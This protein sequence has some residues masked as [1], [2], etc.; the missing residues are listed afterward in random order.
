MD[1]LLV[2][3]RGGG[4][5]VGADADYERVRGQVVGQRAVVEEAGVEVEVVNFVSVQK[6][7][8]LLADALLVGVHAVGDVN[9]G[10]A[11]IEFIAVG[12]GGQGLVGGYYLNGADY[13]GGALTGGVEEADAVNLVSP[14][15]YASGQ[16]RAHGEDVYY[17]AASAG[18]AGG[19]HG[20]LE[21]VSQ[22]AP[23]VER[24]IEVYHVADAD[25]MGTVLE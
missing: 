1:A 9:V 12:H 10:H 2:V 11:M 8:E 6:L 13:L 3:P 19:V 17:A 25:F 22:A 21:P 15:L 24:I 20:G 23:Q 18:E 14:K 16:G 4:H 7:G 5:V